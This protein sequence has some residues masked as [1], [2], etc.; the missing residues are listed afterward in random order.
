MIDRNEVGLSGQIEGPVTEDSP[1]G[2]DT[3]LLFSLRVRRGFAHDGKTVLAPMF[4]RCRWTSRYS[5]SLRPKLLDGS[6]IDVEGRLLIYQSTSM[7]E[8]NQRPSTLVEVNDIVLMPEPPVNA[9]DLGAADRNV[10]VLSGRLGADAEVHLLPSNTPSARF[11]L[12]VR[13]YLGRKEGGTQRQ[14]AMWA[15][16]QWTSM[17]AERQQEFL[18]KGRWIIQQGRLHIYQSAA[19]RERNEPPDMVVAVDRIF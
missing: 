15:R 17:L 1:P 19:M 4:V 12:A 6:W 2:G 18:T 3:G 14:D 16:C 13:R 5:A 9:E 11:T 10:V 8:R 7:R